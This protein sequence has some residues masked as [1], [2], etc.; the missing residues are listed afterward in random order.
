MRVRITHLKA[1]WPQVAVVGDVLDLP[2]VPA[3]ALGKC[4]QVGDDVEITVGGP[5]E[6]QSAAKAQA[7]AEAAALEAEKKAAEELAEADAKAAAKAQA[8]ALGIVVDGRWSAARISDEIT[9][10]QAE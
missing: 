2:E 10:K 4:V 5:T 3:W 8:K 9:K 1:P 7:D 6:D